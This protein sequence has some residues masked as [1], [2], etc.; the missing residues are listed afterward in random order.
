MR[1]SKMKSRIRKTIKSKSTSKRRIHCA[2]SSARNAVAYLDGW[3]K[4]YS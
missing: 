1:K 3:M 2:E 4:S